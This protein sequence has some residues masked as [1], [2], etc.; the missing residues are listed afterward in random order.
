MKKDVNYSYIIIIEV[1]QRGNTYVYKKSYKLLDYNIDFVYDLKT[2]RINFKI[3]Q[4]I[5]ELDVE[6][7]IIFIDYVKDDL[8]VYND[9]VCRYID[10]T[11]TL[12]QNLQ[13]RLLKSK[14]RCKIIKIDSSYIAQLSDSERNYSYFS[15]LLEL[16]DE[17]IL[18]YICSFPASSY[19]DYN[20]SLLVCNNLNCFK[21]LSLEIKKNI[22]LEA[23]IDSSLEYSELSKEDIN[24]IVEKLNSAS[25]KIL[26]KFYEKNILDFLDKEQSLN[27]KINWYKRSY[28]K[29]DK[30]KTIELFE[31]EELEIL[32]KKE[33]SAIMY[34]PDKYRTT[35][36]WLNAFEYV[37]SIPFSKTDV[38]FWE[39]IPKQILDE[40]KIDRIIDT[41]VLALDYI[42]LE[43]LDDDKFWAI[44]EKKA[45][46]SDLEVKMFKEKFKPD[47]MDIVLKC[48]RISP[49]LVSY[50]PL[51]DEINEENIGIFLIISPESLEYIPLNKNLVYS[52]CLYNPDFVANLFNPNLVHYLDK[53]LLE[54]FI[55]KAS[56]IKLSE[57]SQIELTDDLKLLLLERNEEA[58]NNNKIKSMVPKK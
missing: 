5:L 56:Y 29:I 25:Y 17:Q 46:I 19:Q 24:I 31:R 37:M 13:F 7:F 20:C 33:P 55:T 34:A 41:H 28:S 26:K 2:S 9:V 51:L 6:E 38:Y 30:E 54:L 23:F 8:N 49:L 36:R 52:F 1:K 58:N 3:A 53:F 40:R 42:S 32:L 10:I 43:S 12:P 15:K 16:T 14:T 45:Y 48:F 21:N 47:K 57:L 11:G 44:I 18:D 50:K 35:E 39:I 22:N 4:K 27:F